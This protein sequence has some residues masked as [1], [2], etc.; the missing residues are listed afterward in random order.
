[1][2]PTYFSYNWSLPLDQSIAAI[3]R[4]QDFCYSPTI[5]KEIGFELNFFRGIEPSHILLNFFGAYYGRPEDYQDIVAPF[6]NTMVSMAQS[7][8]QVFDTT[9]CAARTDIPT[10]RRGHH[11]ARASV[12]AT[13][14]GTSQ[15][16]QRA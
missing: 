16:L 12:T 6:L 7:R 5:P 14:Q 13:A 3:T 9:F 1:M 10:A 15:V 4:Y 8:I 2:K 11:M